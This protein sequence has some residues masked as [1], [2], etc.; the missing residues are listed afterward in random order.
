MSPTIREADFWVPPLSEVAAAIRAGLEAS[1]LEV[2]IAVELCPDLREMGCAFPG[3]GGKPF[4]VE[5]GGEPYVHNPRFREQGSFDL[6]EIMRTCGRPEGRVLGAGFPSL[7]ATNGRCGELMPCLEMDGRSVSKLARVGPQGQCLVEDYIS[8]LHGGL[9]NLYVCDGLPGNVLSI[10]VRRR[11]G[12]EPS[13]SQCI[14]SALAPMVNGLPGLEIAM[15]G[16]F[17]VLDGRVRAHVSPN[18]ECVPFSYYDEDRNVV[19]R[20]DFLQYYDGMGPDLFCM[21]VLWTGDPTGGALHLRSTGE[22][23]HFFSTAGRAEAGHYHFDVDPESIHCRG[24]FQL[25]ERVIRVADIY[26]QLEQGV[27]P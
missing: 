27:T 25:A 22:H 6:D 8:H 7:V 19:T 2:E 3:L 18:F 26:A 1:F 13:L 4:I 20:P 11:T 14:R 15:G 16:V 5:I 21:S 17:S 9:G 24:Y 12:S 23:T 10:E